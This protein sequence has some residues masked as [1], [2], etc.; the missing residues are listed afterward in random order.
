MSEF[1]KAVILGIVEGLT[2]FLPISSTGHLIIFNDFI[3]FTGDFANMFNIVIQLG[4]ILAVVV[5]YWDKLYPF[6]P[7]KTASEKAATWDIWLK[8]VVGFLPAMFAGAL[9]AERIEEK[10]FNPV[11]VAVALLIGGIILIFIEGRPLQKPLQKSLQKPLSKPRIKFDSVGQLKYKTVFYIG[12]IQCLA[13]IPG[14]S[15][16]AATII[17]AMLLGASR[18]AAAEYSFFLAIPTI[19]AASVYSLFTVGF[20]LNTGQMLVLGTGFA[21]SFLVAWLVIAGFIKYISKKD[22]KPFGYYRIFLG[23]FILTIF[24]LK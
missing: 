9:F 20:S 14:T 1:I 7:S 3:Q 2:E 16:S 24:F 19:A 11:T 10:L 8:T 12:L 21:V 5:Y 23:I 6:H 15:R 18:V 22:F 17:G 4:A 13:M